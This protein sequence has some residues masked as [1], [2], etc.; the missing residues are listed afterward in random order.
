MCAIF[1]AASSR[2]PSRGKSIFFC[3]AGA[4]CPGNAILGRFF[5]TNYIDGGEAI[6]EAFRNLG[7]DYIL[8][9][10]GSE[11]A[12]VWEALARQ[13][14]DK[15]TGPIYIDC[16]HEEIAVA[17]ASGYTQMTGKM[18]AVLL[19]AGA[20]LLHGA[21]AIQGVQQTEAPMIIM[22]GEGLTYGE[23]PGFEPGMQWYRS[24]SVV[25]G[26][27][28]LVEPIV[29]W[30][31][32]ATSVY[33]LYE[34]IVRA[35]ELAQRQP[36]GPV[37]LNVPIE[38]QLHEWTRPAKTRRVPPAPVSRPDEAAIERLAKLL[39]AA[40][41]PVIET[42]G[43][44]R[45]PQAVAAL[46]ELAE[47][48]A[49]PVVEGASAVY[50]NFPKNHPLHQGTKIDPFIKE[51][52]LV[53]L[54]NSR[55]PWYPPANRPLNAT[56]AAIGENPIK[57]HM[58]YQHLH[59]DQ[60]LEGDTAAILRLL[61]AAVRAEGV[62][63]GLVTGRRERWSRA[64]ETMVAG[65]R[66]AEAKVK[67]VNPVDPLWLCAQLREV[68]PADTIYVDETVVHS[69]MVQQHL[70]WDLPQSYFYVLGGLGQGLGVSLGIK[71][72][73]RKRPVV[74]LVGDGTFL[75]N[76]ITQGLGASKGSELPLLIIVFNNRSY[77][78]MKNNH[79]RYY[80]DGVAV[81]NEL[82]HGV[83]ID[84]PD[85]AELGHPFGFHGQK[86]EDPGQLKG[87]LTAALAAVKGGR[88]AILNIVLSR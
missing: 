62:D 59:A 3:G 38:T 39:V 41:H 7:V 50:A 43:A 64:H 81:R 11:W 21:M 71:L 32:Q 13:K 69:G 67:G 83:T 76:P 79:L 8:S 60:Y 47:L 35:G 51:T 45:D 68:M 70:G 65:L 27:Q 40:Q 18:Q 29:K 55:A 88:T 1:M 46:V 77:Q 82:Y 26:P 34:T 4:Q 84:G 12:S 78:A 61:T 44:G 74:L 48:L 80:P 87:A 16:W 24:L 49:I 28:R 20:G 37:Y 85:Y 15:T 30:S 19:H 31:T 53:L 6:L 22:S 25:G 33:S 54:V 14:T 73:E 42:Q 72:A 75:Y 86:V 56:I 66:T 23:Q 52:D 5:V 58:V 10:P 63:R 9:S 36:R 17:M 57:T 2:K